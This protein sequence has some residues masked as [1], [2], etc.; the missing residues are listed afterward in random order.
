[1]QKI[2]TRSNRERLGEFVRRIRNEKRL[3]LSDVSKHSAL[4]GP[5]ISGSYINRIERNPKIKVTP[6]KL[7]SL[8]HGLRIPVEE[9]FAHAI[10]TMTREEADIVSLMTRFRE[11]SPKRKSDVVTLIEFLVLEQSPTKGNQLPRGVES[12]NE[13]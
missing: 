5:R 8:A 13:H 9:I 2:K 7:K 4:F 10:K 6:H 1:M 3:S 11:L 12:N